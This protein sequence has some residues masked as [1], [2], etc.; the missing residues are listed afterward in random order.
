MRVQWIL[1]HVRADTPRTIAMKRNPVLLILAACLGLS[2]SL[3]AQETRDALKEYRSGSLDVAISICLEE[4]RANPSNVESHIVLCWS[5]VKLGRHT[6]A[7][8]YADKARLLSRY[9]PRIIEIQGEIY[10]YQG[11]NAEALRLFQE[12]VNLAPDGGRIDMVFYFLG[13]IYLRLGRFRHADIAFTTAIKYVPGNALWWNRLGYARE[14]AGENQSAVLAYNQ[15]LS[16][17]PQL[18][19]AQRGLERLRRV[20]GIR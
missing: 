17:N 15:A 18:T 8:T 7:E 14:N 3:E 13:E 20:M 5:L 4:I 9:D 2:L 12:Y 19:D 11:R 1:R 6:E 16:L 10:Y